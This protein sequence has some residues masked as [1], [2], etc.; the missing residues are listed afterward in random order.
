VS[1]V[2]IRWNPRWAWYPLALS[3]IIPVVFPMVIR[4]PDTIAAM[5]QSIIATGLLAG[6]LPGIP[7]RRRMMNDDQRLLS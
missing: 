1:A 5:T 7:W 4:T 3:W 6:L 2:V